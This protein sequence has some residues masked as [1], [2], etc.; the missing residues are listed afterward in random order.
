MGQ[1]APENDLHPV[2]RALMY[3]S[4]QKPRMAAIL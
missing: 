2:P 1:Y 4:G 3:V